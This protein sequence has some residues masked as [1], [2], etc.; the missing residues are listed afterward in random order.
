MSP[1]S[2]KNTNTKYAPVASE[3]RQL[4]ST[5]LTKQI[6]AIANEKL[7]ITNKIHNTTSQPVSWVFE[8][9]AILN[10]PFVDFVDTWQTTDSTDVPTFIF[11]MLALIAAES[12]ITWTSKSKCYKDY[13]GQ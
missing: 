3:E 10:L 1:V 9:G 13:T 2:Y 7:P 5:K 12:S 8:N 4:D 6:L 11:Y